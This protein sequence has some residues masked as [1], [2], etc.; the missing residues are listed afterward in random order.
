LPEGI[1][2]ATRAGYIFKF[3]TDE[4]VRLSGERIPSTRPGVDAEITR[5]PVGGVVGIITPW[6]FPLAIPAWK[7][8]S[9]LACGNAVVF[10]PADLVP[11]CAWALAGRSGAQGVLVRPS[12]ARAVRG[13]VLHHRE[14]GVRGAV[15]AGREFFH[16]GRVVSRPG[17]RSQLEAKALKL[18][19]GR[20]SPAALAGRSVYGDLIARGEADLFLTACTNAAVAVRQ[21]PDVQRVQLPPALAVGAD[22]GVAVVSGPRAGDATTLVAFILSPAGQAV[23]ERHGFSRSAAPKQE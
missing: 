23:L 6:N 3:F 11:G 9:A 22:C 13:R 20:D 12:R 5:E 17:A 14:D 4:V 18:T 1:G 2:E 16:P 19:G 21:V 7:I 15:T 8:A 10:K